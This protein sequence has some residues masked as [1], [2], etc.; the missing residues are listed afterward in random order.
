MSSWLTYG[1]L[2]VD[3]SPFTS[4]TIPSAVAKDFNAGLGNQ[5][6]AAKEYVTD[7]KDQKSHEVSDVHHTS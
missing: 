2:M 3:L 6:E 5:A 4:L 1:R 7:K